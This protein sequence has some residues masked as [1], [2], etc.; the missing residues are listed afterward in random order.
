MTPPNLS[1]LIRITC[2]SCSRNPAAG[3]TASRTPSAPAAETQ[4][5]HVAIVGGK[6]AIRYYHRVGCTNF[7][8]AALGAAHGVGSHRPHA[9]V[10]L[11]PV[12]IVNDL[13]WRALDNISRCLLD[14]KLVPSSML[15]PGVPSRR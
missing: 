10:R 13:S 12:R 2:S 1:I 5:K 8:V 6:A 4:E 7:A 14:R 15:P 11:P 3:Q 9:P